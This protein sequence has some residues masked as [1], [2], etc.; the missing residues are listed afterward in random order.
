[1]ATRRRQRYEHTEQAILVSR[2]NHFYPDALLFAVPNGGRRGKAEASRLKDEGVVAGVSD[3]ILL[4]PRGGFFGAVIEMKR[5]DGGR[6]LSPEQVRFFGR[7]RRR[8]YHTI[9]GN[10]AEDAWE[11]VEDYLS[12]SETPR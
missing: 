5:S 8:G 10:G 1:M 4:E 7:A 2:V 11:Q 6:G 3:L 12:M 9:Q